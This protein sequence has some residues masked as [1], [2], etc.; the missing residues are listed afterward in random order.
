MK[1]NTTG[2]D[3]RPL[4]TGLDGGLEGLLHLGIM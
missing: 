1:L 2:A 4:S 3:G